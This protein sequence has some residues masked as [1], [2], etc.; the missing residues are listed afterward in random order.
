MAGGSA[1]FSI[2][3]A[4]SDHPFGGNPAAVVF[5]DT[6]LAIGELGKL[7]RNFN[8]PILVVVSPTSLPSE[9]GVE[10]RS[11]RFVTPRGDIEPPVCGHGTLAAAKVIFDLPEFTAAR[12]NVIHFETAFGERLEARRLEDGWIEIEIPSTTPGD[13]DDDEKKRLKEYVD[14]S[15]GRDV[16]I[17]DIK[18]GG[19]VY[20]SC[21]FTCLR[22]FA[23]LF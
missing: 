17:K 6:S 18:T 14:R 13:V 16:K 3:L 20:K 5:L 9:T 22:S 7:A 2:A 23:T 4:F 11:I 19:S 21:K 8:Q 1:P 10:R 12:K 15:F